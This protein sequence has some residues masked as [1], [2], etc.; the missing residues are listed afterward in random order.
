MPPAYTV[1][2]SATTKDIDG[3]KKIEMKV[4]AKNLPVNS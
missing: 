2:L 4:K 1:T 3:E